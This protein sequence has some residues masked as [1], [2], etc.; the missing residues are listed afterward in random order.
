M[1]FCYFWFGVWWK[2]T[3]KTFLTSPFWAR[4]WPTANLSLLGTSGSDSV[5]CHTDLNKC[6]SGTQ[7]Q[8]HGDWCSP[9]STDRVP[10]SNQGSCV[11]EGREAQRVDL[12][13]RNSAT[14][15]V[16]IYRCD[17]PTL[18]V[19]DYDNTSVRDSPVY[20]GLYNIMPVKVNW[21]LLSVLAKTVVIIV[22]Q[23]N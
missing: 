2:S 22:V 15:P 12:R 9:G 4:L 7:D 11:Y 19:H 13:R 1:R 16:G 20:V 17:I 6:Y 23:Y 18:A 21:Q 3:L 8:H 5:Q 14:S 10:F